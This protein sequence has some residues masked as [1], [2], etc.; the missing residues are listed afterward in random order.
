M[1]NT[2]VITTKYSGAKEFDSKQDFNIERY[3]KILWPT[4]K[5]VH[6]INTTIKDNTIRYCLYRSTFTDRFD[7]STNKERLLKDIDCSWC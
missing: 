4:P 1:T 2:R 6:H 7:Y 3:S 5:L